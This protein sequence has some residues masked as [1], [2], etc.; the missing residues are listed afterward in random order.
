MNFR[1]HAVALAAALLGTSLCLT[2]CGPDDHT[3]FPT[4]PGHWWYYRVL[5]SIRGEP[6]EQRLFVANL[7]DHQHSLRQRKQ[8]R[9]DQLYSIGKRGVT[10]EAFVDRRNAEAV[11][12]TLGTTVLPGRLETGESWKFTSRLRLVESRTFSAEDRLGRRYLPIAMSAEIAAT[13]EAVEVAAGRFTGCVRVQARGTTMVPADR[14][15][16]EVEVSASQTEWYAPGVGLVKLTRQETSSSPFLRNGDY[17][18]E[19]LE[20]GS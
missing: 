9:W 15:N 10:L 5:T 17:T 18:Q 19:L 20:R 2:A 13:D 3:I 4:A 8:G 6:Q 7:S 16:L 1:S 12:H 14:G 11:P